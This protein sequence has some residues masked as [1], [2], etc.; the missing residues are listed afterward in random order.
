MIIVAAQSKIRGA[1]GMADCLQLAG[2]ALLRA[3]ESADMHQRNERSGP[4][5]RPTPP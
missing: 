2:L 3:A 1:A 5:L 4:S